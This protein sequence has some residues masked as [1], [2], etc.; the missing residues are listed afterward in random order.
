MGRTAELGDMLLCASKS[1]LKARSRVNSLE[2]SLVQI[3]VVRD[4]WQVVTIVEALERF[5]GKNIAVL[6]EMGYVDGSR[7]LIDRRSVGGP[8]A[9]AGC[10]LA[11]G[12]EGIWTWEMS[13]SA[14]S[15][16]SVP[17]GLVVL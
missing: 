4:F 17:T 9:D 1:G 14:L 5:P 6:S 3:G 8:V 11:I 12:K 16:C 2:G 15:S 7:L 10:G 13:A